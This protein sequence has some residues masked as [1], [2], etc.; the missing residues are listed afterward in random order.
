MIWF[1]S[2]EALSSVKL[3]EMSSWNFYSVSYSKKA[4]NSDKIFSAEHNEENL[5]FLIEVQVYKTRLLP[6]TRAYHGRKIVDKFIK[7][8]SEKEVNIPW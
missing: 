5:E 1:H 4:K 2:P 8:G 3:F 7:T 6:C